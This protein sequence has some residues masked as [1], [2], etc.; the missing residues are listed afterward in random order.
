VK[1]AA[2]DAAHDAAADSA[3]DAFNCSA[4]PVNGAFTYSPASPGINSPVTFTPVTGGLTYAWT[5]AAGTPATSTDAAPQA[6]WSA[7]GQHQVQLTVT[8]PA[9]TCAGSSM[10]DVTVAACAQPVGSQVF[11]NSLSGYPGAGLVIVPSRNTSLTS[12][13]MMNQ[14]QADTINLTDASGTV[15]QTLSLPASTPTFVATVNWPLTA[16]VTYHLVSGLTNNGKW[17]S[18]T[19]WPVTGTSLSITSAW[20]SGAANPNYY[21][22]F[23]NLVTCP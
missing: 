1:K 16:N 11:A 15:L 21:L 18:F 7:A 4:F 8:D 22:T 17:N 20:M 5:F 12:F 14:G 2:P 19:S 13:T 10:Q 3:P 9:T 6:V 23:I